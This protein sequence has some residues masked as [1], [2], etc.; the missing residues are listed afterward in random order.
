MIK[1]DISRLCAELRPAVLGAFPVD[2][3]GDDYDDDDDIIVIVHEDDIQ[4][5]KQV[6]KKAL[7]A[8]YVVAENTEDPEELAV[9]KN[10]DLEQLS[11]YFCSF[12]AMVFGSETERNLH[13]RVHY[14]GFG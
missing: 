13:Q 6:L 14:F 9:L 1:V 3:G 7:P 10:G 12:C 4:K 5:V 11:L 2:A 8:D